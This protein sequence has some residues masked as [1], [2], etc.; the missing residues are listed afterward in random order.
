MV[1]YKMIGVVLLAEGNVG[2]TFSLFISVLAN[3]I[4][5][6]VTIPILGMYGALLSSVISYHLWISF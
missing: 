6:I 4:A 3:I 2:F 1:F 5:N